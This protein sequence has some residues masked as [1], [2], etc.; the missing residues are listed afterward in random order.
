MTVARLALLPRMAAIYRTR[1]V[2]LGSGATCPNCVRNARRLKA[3]RA[4]YEGRAAM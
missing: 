4:T 3:I 2:H 1:L